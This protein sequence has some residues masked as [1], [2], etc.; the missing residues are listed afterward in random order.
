MSHAASQA[1]LYV[2]VAT[3]I[4][5]LI[6]LG[7]YARFR[8][9]LATRMYGIVIS[10]CYVVC[11]LAYT[12]GADSRP[13]TLA[14]SALVA[15]VV[16][17]TFLYVLYRSVVTRAE[18][19]I[20]RS[21]ASTEQ[22]SQAAME[23]AATAAEQAATVSEVSASIE[24]MTQS[25]AAAAAFAVEVSRSS[26]A[27]TA[28]GL[29][30]VHAVEETAQVLDLIGQVTEVVESVRDFAEQSNMLAVNARIEAAKAGE[31]G[32]GFAVVATEIRSLAE[33]SKTSAQRIRV[34]VQ[35]T[36][37]GSKTVDAARSAIK[38]LAN[39]LADNNEKA[40]QIATSTSDQ[41]VGIRQVSEAMVNVAEG[42]RNTEAAAKQLEEAARNLSHMAAD[43][44]RFVS[45]G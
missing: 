41:S 19:I 36:E 29:Q 43:L 42:G 6:I 1:L 28:E 18:T 5:A 14:V 13:T 12:A 17:T 21:L 35:R 7:V 40:T 24:Q 23:L 37:H 32:R 33:Q 4:G 10:L 27:A 38:S 2:A 31:H 8:N 44:K 11:G 25:A 20:S 30:G 16:F 39:I 3:P 9:G 26:A 22:V 45:G 34:A 15:G